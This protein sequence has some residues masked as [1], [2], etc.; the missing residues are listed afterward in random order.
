MVS[1]TPN[2]ELVPFFRKLGPEFHSFARRGTGLI[3]VPV[4]QFLFGF[5]FDP[6]VGDRRCRWLQPFGFPLYVPNTFVRLDYGERIPRNPLPG[7]ESFWVYVYDSNVEPDLDAENVMRGIGLPMLD[8]FESVQ[9]FSLFLANLPHR[10]QD[11]YYFLDMAATSAFLGDFRS[12]RDHIASF[13]NYL[14]N[15]KLENGESKLRSYQNEKLES[16]E[17]LENLIVAGDLAEVHRQLSRWREENLDRLNIR[18]IAV[19]G[20]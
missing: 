18:D 3:Q 4:Q 17:V 15:W 12:A 9:S 16:A 20:D 14:E 6:K 11:S 13:R 10:K 5:Q 19:P 2:K 8:R 7:L 1:K